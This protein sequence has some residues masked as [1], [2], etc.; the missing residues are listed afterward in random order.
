MDYCVYILRCKDGSLYTGCTNDLPRR[1]AAHQQG[2]GAKYTRSRLPVELVYQEPQPDR[3][4]ALRR[5]AALKRLSRAEKLRLIGYQ[6]RMI[7]M[8]RTDREQTAEF[9]WDIF[10][11]CQYAV[12]SMADSQGRPYSVPVSIACGHGC[13][14]FHSALEGRKTDLLRQNPHVCI[15]CVDDVELQAEQFT[16]KYKSAIA[17]GTARELLDPTEKVQ[18]LRCL[19][20]KLGPRQP[21]LTERKI[22]AGLE[23]TAV[24]RITVEQITGKAKLT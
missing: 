24:W 20:R 6:E 11:K 12:L 9:A 15:T 17:F 8:R 16:T 2:Q 10:E 22:Q 23:R 1:L 3:S 13:V 7:F 19:C 4:N 18:G 14:Y 21:E 5:E